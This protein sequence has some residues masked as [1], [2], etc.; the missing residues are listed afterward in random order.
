[1]DS[2]Y[3]GQSRTPDDS[4]PPESATQS[5]LSGDGVDATT[6]HSPARQWQPPE[7]GN[8]APQSYYDN[9]PGLYG[10]Y[11]SQP[12]QRATNVAAVIIIVVAI[13]FML[14]TIVAI[15]TAFFIVM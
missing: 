10:Q 3:S 2:G 1:M 11:S 15:F 5:S 6:D 4:E 8:P 14:F 7:S 12:A 9:G 13:S